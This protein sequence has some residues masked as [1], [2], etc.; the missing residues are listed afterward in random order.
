MI[1]ARTVALLERLVV[2][3]ERLAEPQSADPHL[4]TAMADATRV[5]RE[6]CRVSEEVIERRKAWEAVE[7]QHM[8]ECARRFHAERAGEVVMAPVRH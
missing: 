1:F 6:A 5:Q 4:L 8:A 3:V 2:A 7:R